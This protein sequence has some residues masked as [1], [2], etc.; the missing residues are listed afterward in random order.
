M[1][2]LV[3]RDKVFSCFSMN[4]SYLFDCVNPFMT[5]KIFHLLSFSINYCKFVLAIIDLI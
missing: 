3:A 4:E 2:P 1:L 5:N